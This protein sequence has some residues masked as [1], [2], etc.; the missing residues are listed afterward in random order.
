MPR[1]PFTLSTTRPPA[2]KSRPA[3]QPN[4]TYDFT[5]INRGG[6]FRMR[7]AVV[8]VQPGPRIEWLVDNDAEARQDAIRRAIKVAT[9]NA[10]AAVGDGPLHVVEIDVNSHEPFDGPYRDREELGLGRLGMVPVTARVRV[11]FGY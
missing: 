1:N 11:T 4:V 10:R 3:P 7:M 8:D 9:E 5:P 2:A 6:G